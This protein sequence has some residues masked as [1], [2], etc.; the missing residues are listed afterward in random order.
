MHHVWSTA[1]SRFSEEQLSTDLKSHTRH[2]G[3]TNSEFLQWEKFTQEPSPESPPA[4]YTHPAQ[5]AQT[6]FDR[7]LVAQYGQSTENQYAQALPDQQMAVEGAPY[8][9]HPQGQY[10]PPSQAQFTHSAQ[11]SHAL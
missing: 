8:T 3:E 2:R 4:L 5:T 1:F 7:Y 11:P 6:P 10:I 9:Q